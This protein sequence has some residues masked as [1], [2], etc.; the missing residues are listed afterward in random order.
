MQFFEIAGLS[1]RLLVYLTCVRR[2]WSPR[3]VTGA[4]TATSGRDSVM[5]ALEAALDR[6][7]EWRWRLGRASRRQK[8]PTA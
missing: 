6:L 7:E 8:G 5:G 4:L 2:K 1:T 3:Q